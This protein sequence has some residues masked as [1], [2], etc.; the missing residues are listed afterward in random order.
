MKQFKSHLLN[1]KEIYIRSGKD[2]I[3][4]DLI[5]YQDRIKSK[6]SNKDIK[7]ITCI[8]KKQLLVHY[9]DC[10]VLYTY[11]GNK[12]YKKE[13]IS[14]NNLIEVLETIKISKSITHSTVFTYNDD[15]SIQLVNTGG[16]NVLTT[17]NLVVI[18]GYKMCLKMND[19][20]NE[21][22][23]LENM[24]VSDIRNDKFKITRIGNNIKCLIGNKLYNTKG[25]LI[26]VIKENQKIS[27]PNDGSKA[28]IIELNSKDI[29]IKNLEQEEVY[30]LDL[31]EVPINEN[32]AIHHSK[33]ILDGAEII[34]NNNYN[35]FELYRQRTKE[36]LCLKVILKVMGKK[37][38]I[39]KIQLK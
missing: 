12:L 13:T 30:K 2:I 17:N 7:K 4:T 6:S 14:S 37:F 35:G 29:I 11:R 21:I 31:S 19:K 24:T 25:E 27:C 26:T 15:G 1:I 9:D 36:E 38:V 28:F 18:T 22:I 16:T 34:V 3:K 5:L 32:Y 23:P 20:L 33:E 39:K 10:C 8:G